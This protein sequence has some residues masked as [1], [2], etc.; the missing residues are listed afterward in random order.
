MFWPIILPKKKPGARKM[1][2]VKIFLNK[3]KF[4]IP[5]GMWLAVLLDIFIFNPIS[6][7]RILFLTGLWVLTI[8]LY[9]FEGRASIGGGLVF[10][11][12][13][14]FLLIFGKEQMAEKSAIWAYVFLVVGVI[15]SFIW[16]F[17]KNEK[18]S[19]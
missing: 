3:Y 16:S 8:W 19:K 14:P 6:E 15:Q 17:S 7:V 13:C 2:K 12:F 4:L 9:G 10:L 5:A 1:K 11:I 18:K